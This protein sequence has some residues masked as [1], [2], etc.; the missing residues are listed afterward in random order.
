[1]HVNTHLDFAKAQKEQIS[2]LLSET[3]HLS[4]LP[5][6]YTADWNFTF[7]DAP[8]NVIQAAGYMDAS[9]MTE[10]TMSGAT[11]VGSGSEIDFCFTSV[12][13]T[14]VDSYMV[15][16][17]HEFSETSSDHY[18]IFVELQIVK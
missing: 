2:I 1:M 16:N 10:N 6:F 11:L 7:S 13:N 14:S 15:I 18:P 8:Y 17:E 3:A 5:M 9:I 12:L 4:Y